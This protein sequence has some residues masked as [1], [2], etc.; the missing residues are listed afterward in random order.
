M[1][2]GFKTLTLEVD[3][4]SID[5]SFA[6]I[7]LDECVAIRFNTRG[8]NNRDLGPR[9]PANFKPGCC[10]NNG[11]RALDVTYFNQFIGALALDQEV[12]ICV[13]CTLGQ[14]FAITSKISVGDL[15]WR[16]SFQAQRQAQVCVLNGHDL[17][18]VFNE[19]KSGP[20]L[21]TS[22]SNLDLILKESLASS[23]VLNAAQGKDIF[24]SF[25]E[26]VGL[27][28]ETALL[29]TSDSLR[30]ALAVMNNLPFQIEGSLSVENNIKFDF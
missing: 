9:E 30:L 12:I 11:S 19:A 28:P 10:R 23:L 7:L 29:N 22:H 2:F 6:N 1:I 4:K 18:L 27:D 13:I 25:A 16:L 24:S 26:C 20:W 21:L 5:V 8:F 15:K 17:L 14:H 3:F